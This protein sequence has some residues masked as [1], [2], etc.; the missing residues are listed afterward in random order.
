MKFYKFVIKVLTPLIKF[1]LRIKVVDLRKSKEVPLQTVI[2]ANHM[3]NWDPIITVVTTG[4][5]INFMAKESLFKVPILKNIIKLFGAFPVNR[6]GVDASAIKR[7]VD[8][9]KNGGCF[10]LFPQG[11]RIQDVPTADQAKKGVGFICA[12]AKA[13]VLPVGIYTKDYR[14]KL[15]KKVVVTIGDVIRYED[16]DFGEE[17][18][19]YLLAS[20][21]IFAVICDLAKP[22][23]NINGN[24]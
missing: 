14:V 16:I 13:G 3:S 15:F 17:G 20:Q 22:E 2:C 8:I 21:K 19:D 4:M 9:I 6:G 5:P 7:S 24:N 1:I 11:K 23:V 18:D 10:S 12:K